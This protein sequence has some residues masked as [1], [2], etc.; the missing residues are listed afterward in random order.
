MHI[1]LFIFE[2]LC[3][4]F[5]VVFGIELCMNLFYICRTACINLEEYHT[6]KIALEK[7][8]SFA[9]DDSRFTNLIQQCQRFI[10]AG[11]NY[12]FFM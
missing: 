12:N 1:N 5:R 2:Y 7:G 6:A 10:A 4:V 3:F 9:P 11:M 8:A